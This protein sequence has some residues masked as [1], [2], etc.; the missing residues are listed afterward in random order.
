MTEQALND[1]VEAGDGETRSSRRRMRRVGFASFTGTLIEFYDFN[2]YG[3]AAALVFSKVFF[4]ALGTAA[5]T[6][7]AFATLGVAFIARPFGSILFGHFGDRL[8]RKKTLVSTLMLMGVA[9]VCVGL[10]P[11]TEKI[12]ILAPILL[13]LMRILQGLGAG[14]EWAGAV[15]FAAEHAPQEK[16][17]FWAMTPSLGAGF[18]VILANSTFLVTGLA[19]SEE[20]F[21]DWGWRIPFLAS[22]LLICVGLFIRL[23]IE[24]TPVF[25]NQ[26]SRSGPVRHPFIDALTSQPREIFLAIGMASVVPVLNYLA[27][28]YLPNY[29][30]TTLE[31]TRTTILFVG[32]AGGASVAFGTLLGGVYADRLGR[33]RVILTSTALAVVWV[34]L[35]FPF[36]GT[37]S[38]AAFLIAIIGTM[39]LG[40]IPYGAQSAYLTEL[41]HT[42]YRYSAAGFSYNIA[43]IIGGAIP[44]M[45]GAAITASFGVNYY[46]VFL[47][48]ILV[49]SLVCTFALGETRQKDLNDVGASPAVE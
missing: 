27:L 6:I 31:L 20:T 10:I 41:F 13:M 37:G 14:G 12:G 42:R 28:A 2:I 34:L 43:T 30:L 36:L 45:I 32:I 16:R 47:A 3:V 18:S 24:E 44:P 40:G 39:V 23:K 29:G 4:P 7:A 8:G 17:G 5:G 15:L 21:M 25:K 46:G 35:V 38:I 22:G 49:F 26:V 48:A 33:R 1:A 11:T 9:T 19:M